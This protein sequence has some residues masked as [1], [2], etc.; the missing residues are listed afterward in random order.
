VRHHKTFPRV[1]AAIPAAKSAA[2]A[3]W[4]VPLPPPATSCSAPS[5]NPPPGRCRSIALMPKGSTNARRLAAP[6]SRR[7][8]ARSSSISGRGRGVF[9]ALATGSEEFM[10]LI[11]SHSAQRVNWSLR[12]G[13]RLAIF[14]RASARV[15]GAPSPAPASG[16]KARSRAGAPLF[17]LAGAVRVSRGSDARGPRDCQWR[18]RWTCFV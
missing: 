2:A 17:S 12:E 16:T 5:A 4:I 10:F 18:R 1:R 8:R 9:M 7:M 15:G 11:C 6:S 14:I 3:P 13:V